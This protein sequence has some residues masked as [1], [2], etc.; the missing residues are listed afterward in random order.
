MFLS[1]CERRLAI[2]QCWKRRVRFYRAMALIS[3][4]L[5]YDSISILR[6]DFSFIWFLA[7]KNKIIS[8][9]KKNPKDLEKKIIRIATKNVPAIHKTDWNY[10]QRISIW[11]SRIYGIYTLTSI[12]P[13]T[14][15]ISPLRAF[16]QYCTIVDGF[17]RFSAF[18]CEIKSYILSHL[19]G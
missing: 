10:A 12:S 7:K 16:K 14:A 15:S 3:C 6:N 8:N 11:H 4:P 5:L 17:H 9:D 18:V 13:F 1:L 19:V 2:F